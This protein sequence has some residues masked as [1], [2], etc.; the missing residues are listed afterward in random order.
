MC[1]AP[2]TGKSRLVRAVA[3]HYA[4]CVTGVATDPHATRQDVRY[5]T[6]SGSNSLELCQLLTS[7][8]RHGKT[9]SPS[10]GGSFNGHMNADESRFECRALNNEYGKIVSNQ[11]ANTLHSPLR[12]DGCWSPST[13]PVVL[14]VEDLHRCSGAAQTL[15]RC[16]GPLSAALPAVIISSCGSAA[17]YAS[18]TRSCNFR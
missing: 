7:L 8:A 3:Q 9:P 15:Q 10:N 18:L 14:V 4:T 2:S 5:F 16:L 17:A 6:V 12:G 11:T 1:G 13:C